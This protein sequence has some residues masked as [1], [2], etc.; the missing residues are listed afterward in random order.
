MLFLNNILICIWKSDQL[1]HMFF[2]IYSGSYWAHA[3]NIFHFII[4]VSYKTSI[5]SMFHISIY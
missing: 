5:S 2:L 1:L 4:Q 3:V